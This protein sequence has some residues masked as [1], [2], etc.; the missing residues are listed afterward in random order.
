VD[1]TFRMPTPPVIVNDKIYGNPNNAIVCHDLMT[2]QKL[3]ETGGTET[4][5]VR[6]LVENACVYINNDS[7]I[8][9]CLNASG[10]SVKWAIRASGSSTELSY[11]NGV[12]YFVGGGDGKLHAIDA[13]TGDYLWKIESPDKGKNKWAVFSGMCAVVPGVG[14]EK[15]KIVVTTGLN[16]YCYEAIR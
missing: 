1:G 15:G 3:W 9:T 7:G 8:L 5:H 4:T 2:G 14:S 12:I 6:I 16:A 11:L 13:N 10:G